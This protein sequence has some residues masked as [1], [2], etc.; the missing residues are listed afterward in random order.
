MSGL[1]VGD[2]TVY[3]GLVYDGSQGSPPGALSPAAIKAALQGP[4]ATAAAAA[5][6]RVSG[7]DTALPRHAP[8][9]RN[10]PLPHAALSATTAF[11]AGQGGPSL[12]PRTQT[13]DLLGWMFL[14]YLFGCLRV[15]SWVCFRCVHRIVVFCPVAESSCWFPVT[16]FCLFLFPFP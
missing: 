1:V 9:V 6:K 2:G 7:Q 13:Q 10:T 4:A 16:L 5:R 8:T 3:V 14:S 12:P 15:I 11:N